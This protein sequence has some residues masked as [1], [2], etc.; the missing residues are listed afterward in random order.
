M[1]F[2]RRHKTRSLSCFHIGPP[3]IQEHNKL[4]FKA[5]RKQR[6][7]ERE[8]TLFQEKPSTSTEN[9]LLEESSTEED[10]SVESCCELALDQIQSEISE[11]NTNKVE[12]VA[13]AADYSLMFKRPMILLYRFK[14]DPSIT[15]TW[16]NSNIQI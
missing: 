8:K 6:A 12:N 5:Q 16:Q 11:R 3:D 14:M 15:V 4:K 1:H 10:S 2:S 13:L 9:V 7:I